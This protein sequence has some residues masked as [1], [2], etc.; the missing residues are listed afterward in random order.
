MKIKP[1]ILLKE[2]FTELL[3]KYNATPDIIS[4]FSAEIEEQY[5]GKKKFYHTL[6]HLQ[7]LLQELKA[8]KSDIKNWDV[9]L[10]SL[11]YHDIIYNAVK[12]DNEEQS[13]ELA[14]KRMQSLGISA[15]IIQKSKLQILATKKHAES[16]D[17]D[18]N[19][20]TDADLAILGQDWETYESYAASV[21]KEYAI[22]PDMVYNAGRR[23]VLK[24]FLE[25][26]KIYKTK[27]FQEKFETQA[28]LN[29]FKELRFL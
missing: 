3:T 12:S 27:H 21:R 4:K 23:K 6:A 14:G 26:D 25:M 9:M 22:Y 8:V 29:I 18:T 19:Y 13:A 7:H 28:K 2:T 1:S 20:F 17:S 16:A 10:F 5:S 11:Y 15:E 24:H